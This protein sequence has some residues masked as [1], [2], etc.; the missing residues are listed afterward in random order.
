MEVIQTSGL[1]KRYKD[2][3]AVD[4]LYL[5]IYQGELFSLLGVNGAGKTTTI[6]MLTC[7][8]RPTSGDAMVGGYSIRK[9][10]A[11]VK[12]LIGVSPQETAVAPNLSVKEN[13]E[14]ICGIHGFSREKTTEKIRKLCSNSITRFAPM[15]PAAPV[16]RIVFPVRFTLGVSMTIS[17]HTISSVTLLLSWPC[18]VFPASFSCLPIPISIN[19]SSPPL[20]YSEH[21]RVGNSPLSG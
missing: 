1:V 13:L 20:R 16:M 9:A 5:S 2:L 14:L 21:R 18:S 19:R 12:R 7:L 11:Q 15:K 10:P 17:S 6:R 8:S 3:T 4:D